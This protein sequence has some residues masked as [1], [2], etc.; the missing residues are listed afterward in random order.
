MKKAYTWGRVHILASTGP[1]ER[2]IQGNVQKGS[3]SAASAHIKLE[4]V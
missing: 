3:Q 1:A 2:T 4:A